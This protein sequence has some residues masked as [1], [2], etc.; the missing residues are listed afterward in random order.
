MNVLG[1]IKQKRNYRSNEEFEE[2]H[3]EGSEQKTDLFQVGAQ[4]DI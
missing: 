2:K 1:E 4:I 3:K